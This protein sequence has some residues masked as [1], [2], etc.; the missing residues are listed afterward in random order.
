MAALYDQQYIIIM[1][2]LTIQ[3]RTFIESIKTKDT[4]IDTHHTHKKKD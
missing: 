4:H 2:T 3:P 1:S